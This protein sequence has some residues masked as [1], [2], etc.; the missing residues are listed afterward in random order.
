M[1]QGGG[2]WSIPQGRLQVAVGSSRLEGIQLCSQDSD[3][4]SASLSAVTATVSPGM[5]PAA[6]RT[7]L[8]SVSAIKVRHF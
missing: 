7:L 2:Y 6:E 5:H 1:T 8:L 3:S 4:N